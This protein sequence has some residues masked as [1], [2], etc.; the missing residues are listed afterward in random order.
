MSAGI[1]P[2]HLLLFLLDGF[3]GLC[4]IYFFE[5]EIHG[6]VYNQCKQEGQRH[7]NQVAC[8]FDVNVEAQQIDLYLPHYEGVEP[9]A[10]RYA[11]ESRNRSK[12]EIFPE[13]IGIGFAGIEAQ[14]LN[15]CN[16]PYSLGNIYICKV[17]KHDEGKGARSGHY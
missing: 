16:F 4:H 7:G 8:K 11:Y 10:H 1:R 5:S 3:Q 15:G 13:N 6:E 17:I 2:A 14:H 9:F 12:H